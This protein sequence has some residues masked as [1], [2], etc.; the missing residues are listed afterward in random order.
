MVDTYPYPNPQQLRMCCFNNQKDFVNMITLK[1]LREIIQGYP[2]DQW[3]HRGP[4][5]RGRL[6]VRNE[7]DVKKEE[8]LAMVLFEDRESPESQFKELPEGEEGK[9]LGSPWKSPE[10]VGP[11]ETLT[12]ALYHSS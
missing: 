11:I 1:I 3:N 8:E 2:K 4:K 7:T 9:E 5:K 6:R 10:E 12:L